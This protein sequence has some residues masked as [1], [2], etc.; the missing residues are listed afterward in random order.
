MILELTYFAA[1]V[2]FIIGLKQMSSPV[3]ARRGILWAGLG[4]AVATLA[5]LWYTGWGTAAINLW[6][7]LAAMALGGVVAWWAGRVVP[8]TAMPQMVAVYN[9]MGGGA[10]AC[11]AALE[12]LGQAADPALHGVT[13]LTLAVL[14]ALIGAVAFSGSMIAFIK[15]QGWYDRTLNFPLQ[16]WVNFGVLAVAVVIGILLLVRP[17]DATMVLIFF[18]L[19]LAYGVMMTLPIGGARH[20]GGDLPV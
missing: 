13:V 16:Q 19:A 8:M 10:A 14:G 5:T 2:L 4:M 12:L 11:I 7:M 15:L 3:H 1:A 6:L 17:I 20:A 18:L 9:G